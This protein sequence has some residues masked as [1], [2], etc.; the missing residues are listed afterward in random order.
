MPEVNF[1]KTPELVKECIRAVGFGNLAVGIHT[2]GVIQNSLGKGGRYTPSAAGSPPN[3]RR[4]SLRNSFGAKLDGPLRAIVTTNSLYAMK[5]ELGGEIRAKNV[6][7]LTVPLNVAAMRLSESKAKMSLRNYPFRWVPSR[8]K[9]ANNGGILVSAL[10]SKA[11]MY[12]NDP[13]TKKRKYILAGDAAPKFALKRSVYLPPRPFIKPSW[14]KVK[15]DPN[16]L[17]IWARAVGK[18]LSNYPR[19]RVYGRFK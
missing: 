2:V 15:N 17:E 18:Q 3:N 12:V 14:Q 5:Q 4:N 13:V 6:K 9:G 16:T 8:K 19:I 1:S 7:F 10:A 11:K